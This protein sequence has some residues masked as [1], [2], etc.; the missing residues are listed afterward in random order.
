MYP[1]G[2][3]PSCRDF[4][5]MT[6]DCSETGVTATLL[7]VLARRFEPDDVADDAIHDKGSSLVV[8]DGGDDGN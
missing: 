5:S 8:E 1:C 7:A 3:L 6:S 4:V 2:E